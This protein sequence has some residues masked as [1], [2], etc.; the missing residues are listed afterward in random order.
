MVSVYDDRKWIGQKFGMLTVVEPVQ[1]WNG[2][3]TQWY[4]KV[5]CDCG[6]EKTAKPRDV[7]SGHQ[8]SCGCYRKNRPGVSLRHGMSHT[9]LHNIWCGMNNRCNPEHSSSKGYGKRG[10]TI[11]EE[12]SVF[13]NFRDWA[14]QNGYEDGLTIERK[15]VNGNY[16]PENCTWI[17]LGKQARNRRTTRWVEYQG[18]TMSLAEAAEIAGLPYKQVHYRLKKGWSLERA[19]SEPLACNDNSLHRRC[20][21]MGLNYH[22]V[23][24]RVYSLGW[25]EEKALS[26]PTLGCGANQTSY[27]F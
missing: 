12:W 24:N 25:G 1:Y 22:T 16:C 17:P 27:N 18:R 6:N 23:Y 3:S 8:V 11:C 2:R 21:E 14:F 20:V 19:L 7:I 9:H 5:R 13:E 4:W 15:D 26:V 10:I